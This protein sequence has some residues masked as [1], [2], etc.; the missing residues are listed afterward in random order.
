M[1]N[2]RRKCSPVRQRV[3][4]AGDG[5]SLTVAVQNAGS[6]SPPQLSVERKHF[7]GGEIRQQRPADGKQPAGFGTVELTLNG[8]INA[9]GAIVLT[10]ADSHHRAYQLTMLDYTAIS[11]PPS[12]VT[13]AS[14][15]A[16][17]QAATPP[18]ALPR[19]SRPF[20][21]S[22]WK[23][24]ARSPLV[25]H[26]ALLI[27]VCGCGQRHGGQSSFQPAWQSHDSHGNEAWR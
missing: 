14:S 3:V 27:N 7:S 15:Y 19:T 24:T 12:N 6:A 22:T 25:L 21:A 20:A 4:G 2:L 9:D 10:L 16:N 26:S 23:S 17:L 1:P 8:T 18:T 5:V 13:V 11:L